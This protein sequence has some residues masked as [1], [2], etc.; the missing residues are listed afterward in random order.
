MKPD[1]LSGI[2][3][4]LLQKTDVASARLF[5]RSFVWFMNFSICPSRQWDLHQ[6]KSILLTL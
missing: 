1:R 6:L 5:Q 4:V 2:L 3:T